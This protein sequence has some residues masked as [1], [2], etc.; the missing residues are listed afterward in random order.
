MKILDNSKKL[1]QQLL[2]N[3][4][5]NNWI[6]NKER[7]ILDC[8]TSAGKTTLLLKNICKRNPHL[9]VLYLCSRSE[10]KNEVIELAEE[11][12]VTNLEFK[13]Y[14]NI[15][16]M[17]QHNELDN[18][19]HYDVIFCDEVHFFSTETTFNDT[20]DYAWNVIENTN[21][22]VIY[23]SATATNLF[24]Y[25]INTKRV[26]EN[27][28]YYM[29]RDYS[30][31]KSVTGYTKSKSKP[32]DKLLI[33]KLLE[34]TTDKIV[35]FVSKI[36]DGL[37][38]YDEFSKKYD[39]AFKCSDNAKPKRAVRISN[40]CG[41]ITD[42]KGKL[43]CRLLIA[44][45]ALDVGINI[46]DRKLKHMIISTPTTNTFI[47]ELG[48]ARKPN[49]NYEL[50]VYVEQMNYN[51]L[52]GYRDSN[53]KIY[54]K[55]NLFLN[56]KEKCKEI[57]GKHITDG[58]YI[59]CDK[60]TDNLVLN[61]VGYIN[62]CML[63]DYYNSIVC[64]KSE[65]LHEYKLSLVETFIE[66]IGLTHKEMNIEGV[67]T[68]SKLKYLKYEDLLLE[69][70]KQ[71]IS[72]IQKLERFI[73]ENKGKPLKKTKRDTLIKLCNI[74]GDKKKL[75]TSYK[76]IAGFLEEEYNLELINKTVWNS[77]KKQNDK[78]WIIQ[79]PEK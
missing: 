12:T 13:T 10:L 72:R 47:Q 68:Y 43:T 60:E 22:T 69:E 67:Y 77:K 71:D 40:K 32:T 33:K 2:I 28:H 55:I 44:T 61:L 25:L 50:N 1:G 70:E 41:K 64:C 7:I 45:S 4:E 35:C 29:D 21:N 8:G 36:N 66:S 11:K 20:V 26:Q 6:T 19:N 3:E 74:R 48:R 53:N 79:E 63:R 9:N 49:N 78:V 56:D 76:T 5:V 39:V 15:A 17:Y 23:A 37:D 38:L 58:N 16:Y 57:Y 30:Y 65:E 31:I 18:L 52:K 24:N 73:R 46:I 14:Q 62:I 59:Y 42:E 27:N 34:E 51:R 75:L 54:D